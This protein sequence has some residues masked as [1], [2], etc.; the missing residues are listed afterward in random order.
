MEL[1]TGEG[2]STR[3]I[4]TDEAIGGLSVSAALG[5]L[6]ANLNRPDGVVGEEDLMRLRS[7][8]AG[9]RE[10]DVSDM[11]TA[12][13]LAIAVLAVNPD[14]LTAGEVGALLNPDGAPKK[15]SDAAGRFITR[16]TRAK[17]DPDRAG[18]TV[19]ERLGVSE[20]VGNKRVLWLMGPDDNAEELPARAQELKEKAQQASKKEHSSSTP[21]S[22]V[23]EAKS[24]PGVSLVGTEYDPTLTLRQRRER[25]Q[26]RLGL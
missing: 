26:R 20:P 25:R 22:R 8:Q 7:V 24:Q 18:H 15:R 17:E 3:G 14:G 12:D 19:A 23:P 13:K 4:R 6:P 5:K 9:G 1:S 16:M 10:H 11:G 2:L 21:R